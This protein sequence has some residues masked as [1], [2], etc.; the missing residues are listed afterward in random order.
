MSI[1]QR[2]VAHRNLATET[3]E[4]RLARSGHRRQMLTDSTEGGRRGVTEGKQSC[5]PFKHTHCLLELSCM[6]IQD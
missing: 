1:T 5:T 3:E 4:A 2:Q 6:A